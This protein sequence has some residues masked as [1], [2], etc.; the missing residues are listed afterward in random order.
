MRIPMEGLPR[1]SSSSCTRCAAASV[2]LMAWGR[3]LAMISSTLVSVLLGRVAA[4]V[5]LAVVANR[6]LDRILG[7]DRA[8]DL[9]RRQRQVLGDLGVLDRLRL[10]QRLALDPFGRERRR[11]NR[12]AATEGL[13]LRVL[14]EAVGADLDLKLHDVTAGGCP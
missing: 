7:Q 4:L 12:R 13:E 14:D 8:V 9:H 11:G 6:R 1:L 3:G 5:L 10:V 2:S